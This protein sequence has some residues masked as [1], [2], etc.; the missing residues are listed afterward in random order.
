MKMQLARSIAMLAMMISI[1]TC[2]RNADKRSEG[3]LTVGE[4]EIIE[5]YVYL[6]GRALAVRQEQT[7][8]GEPGF[9]Y[10]AIKYNEAGKADFVNPNLDVAYMEA[11]F[12]IDGNS[13]VIIE[14]PEIKGR[15]YTVQLMDGWG[16]VLYNI[17][18]RNF[19]DRPSGKYALC[20]QNTTASIPP[21]AVKIV[22][23]NKKVK[24]LARVELQNSWTDAI[25][26][27]RQFSAAVIGQPV[28]EEVPEFPSFTNKGLP[29]LAVFELA[30]DLMQ[31]PD[32]QMPGKD[33]IQAMCDKV[34]RYTFSS[35]E[36]KETVKKVIREKAIP[37]LLNYAISK[38]GKVENNWLG[39]LVGGRYNGNYWTRTSANYVGI[40]ANSTQEVIYF[41]ASND[42]KGDTLKGGTDYVIHFEKERLPAS[43]VNG[44]WSVILVGFPDYRVVENDLKRYNL[45]NYSPFRYEADGSLKIYV[46]PRYNAAWPK[47]NWL[48]SP[49]KGKFNLTLR[50]YVP[51]E[52][53][54]DGN[55][56]PAP[57]GRIEK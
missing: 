2:N 21:E 7:D 30:G 35:D 20:L 56:F 41:I 23:P 1:T 50:M 51:K 44:F 47:A 17:N 13:A 38:A 27:Q 48:P 37:Q 53:V 31:T 18:E 4:K 34:A 10:N 19:P 33:S 29:D 28:I 55:W 57:V 32:S 11:W 46:A 52:N 26:L 16:E 54:R 24:M 3:D 22:V 25:K 39:V 45:N 40:W 8:M 6:L 43:Q 15:Y 49:A 5:S 12:A 14:I 36:N 9:E 42:A